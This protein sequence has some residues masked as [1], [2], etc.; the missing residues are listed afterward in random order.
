VV[1]AWTCVVLKAFS[2]VVLSDAIWVVVSAA[3]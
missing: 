1:S 2:A 3:I